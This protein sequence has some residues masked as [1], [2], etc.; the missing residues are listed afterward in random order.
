MRAR[1]S[2][3]L[4]GLVAACRRAPAPSTEEAAAPAEAPASPGSSG[5]AA[6]PAPPPAPAASASAPIA[7]ASAAAPP[8]LVFVPIARKTLDRATFPIAVGFDGGQRFSMWIEAL[9][10]AREI[11]Q[12]TGRRPR[13]T[14]FVSAAYLTRSAPGSTIGVARSREEIAVR[15]ALLQVAVNEGHEI[16][17]HGVGHEDGRGWDQARWAA[18][19]ATFQ[20]LARE[21]V[22]EPVVRGGAPAFPR[23]APVAAAGAV[24]ARCASDADCTGGLCLE[25]SARERLCSAPCNAHQR[26]PAATFC[27]TPAFV[28]DTDVCLPLPAH[29][30]ALDGAEAFGADGEPKAHPALVPFPVRGFRAP[31]LGTSPGLVRALEGAGYAYDASF[32]VLPG[33]AT[34][35]AAGEPASA[36]ILE[37]GLVRTPGARTIP[38]D[39]NYYHLHE[40]PSRMRA[41]YRLGVVA[42]Y[43]RG[44]PFTIGHHFAAFRLRGG[45]ETYFDVLRETVEW[46]HLGCPD[47]G[48]E[49]CPGARV[50]PYRELAQRLE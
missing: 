34:R 50:V 40:P 23:W 41:D 1:W 38:M 7:S 43:E 30:V 25:L 4:L 26:C 39:Y 29:P 3:L 28:K 9:R 17:D 27:G 44:E 32:T 19:L 6:P 20:S 14:F 36:K 8:P 47:G 11:E 5:P 18:E 22:F 33:P 46:I 48:R 16:A 2:P 12:A 42:A 21:S 24:G 35:V 13:F 37:L 49:R 10:V 31:F 45:P 15:R